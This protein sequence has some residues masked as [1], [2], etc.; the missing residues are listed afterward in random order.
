[1]NE[2]CK[3]VAYI[4]YLDETIKVKADDGITFS[5]FWFVDWFA[6]LL[7]KSIIQMEDHLHCKLTNKIKRFSIFES[8]ETKTKAATTAN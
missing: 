7:C 6:C 5:C 4:L 8:R 3:M 1:M 2:I